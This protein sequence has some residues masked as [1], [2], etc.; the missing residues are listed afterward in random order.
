MII[1]LTG[2]RAVVTGS[3]AG[4]GRATAEGLARAG[5]SVVV[6]GSRAQRV[7]TAV[8]EMREMFPDNEI[9]GVV[10]H[11]QVVALRVWPEATRIDRV[12]QT[13]DLQGN[14]TREDNEVTLDRVGADEVA[15]EARALGFTVLEPRLIAMTNDYVGSEVVMLCA[16]APSIPS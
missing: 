9:N 11:S 13:V 14:R 6:N 15:E 12:R 8:D 7:A 5:A 4:I 2:R 16:S 3:T 1:D 10:Y